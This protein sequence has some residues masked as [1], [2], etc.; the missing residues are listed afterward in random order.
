MY[1][2]ETIGTP[3]GRPM[4]NKYL[5]KSL[6]TSFCAGRLSGGLFALVKR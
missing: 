2:A 1:N 6:V 4:A 3:K 5:I